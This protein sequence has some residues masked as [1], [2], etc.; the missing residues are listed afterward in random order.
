MNDVGIEESF[1]PSRTRAIP[2]KHADYEYKLPPSNLEIVRP[3]FNVQ[4]LDDKFAYSEDYLCSLNN[5]LQIKEPNTY[6][7][8]SQHTGRLEAIETKIAALEHNT[9][10]VVID[11]PVGSMLLIANGCTERK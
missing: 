8:A 10:W 2:R 1:R 4:I 7:E 9:T 5:V 11:L 6:Q 3:T